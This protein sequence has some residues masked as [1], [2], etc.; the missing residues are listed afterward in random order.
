[1]AGSALSMVMLGVVMVDWQTFVNQRVEITEGGLAG[2]VW[3]GV[4]GDVGRSF[5]RSGG[6]V[7]SK[8]G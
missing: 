3:S 6:R 4:G 8:I 7:R 1:M 5:G 2:V